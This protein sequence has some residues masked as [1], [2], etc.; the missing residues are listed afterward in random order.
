M[1]LTWYGHSAFRVEYAGAVILL[2]PFI[3]N[4]TYKGDPKA[5]YQG[6]THVLLTHGH[7]DHTGSAVEICKA[8]DAVLVANPEVCGYLGKHGVEK[9]SPI[10]HGGELHLGGFTAGY[11]PA[12]HSS[13]ADDGTYLGN[14]GGFVLMAPG[15]KTVLAM[16]DTGIF[17]GMKLI[18]EIYQPKVGLVPIG[19]RFT[20]G[21]RLAALACNRFFD[22]ETV[23]PCH[24]GTFGLLDQT[25]DKFIAEMKGATAKVVVPER[26][27]AVEL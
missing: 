25:P 10:N 4:P 26:G 7:G 13:A 8:T 2:D 12:W 21:A 11:V 19:D 1:K 18:G 5:A 22:F 9:M 17:D 3:A 16:G 14:P 20:M 15:E 24:Y 23:V 6:A 27:A